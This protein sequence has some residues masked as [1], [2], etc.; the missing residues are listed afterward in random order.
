[1]KYNVLSRNIKIY[2]SNNEKMEVLKLYEGPVHKCFIKYFILLILIKIY[3][4]TNN[5]LS[6][7]LKSITT[8]I[9]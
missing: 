4:F 6:K 2:L 3:M 5:Y 9:V 8:F 7:L 1:M